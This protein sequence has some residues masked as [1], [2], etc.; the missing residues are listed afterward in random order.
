MR[1]FVYA[2]LLAAAL[3]SGLAAP[4]LAAPAPKKEVPV[5]KKTEP[6]SVPAGLSITKLPNGLMVAIQKDDRFPLAALRLYVHAGSAY[7]TPQQAGISHQLEHMVFKGTEKRPKGQVAADVEKAGGYLNAATSF[8]YTVYLTDMPADKWAL[9]LDIL[10]DMAFHPSLDPQELE[11]EKKV[12]LAELQRGEDEPGGRLFK[13]IQA[14][15][16]AGTPYERP[17]IGY[18]ETIKNFT[19]EGIRAYI[20]QHY[21]PQSMLLVVVGKVDPDKVLAEAARQFGDLPNTK[22]VTPPAVIAPSALPAKGPLVTVERT[23]WNKVHLGI[24]FPAYDQNDARSPALEVLSQLLAGDKT[25]YFYRVYKYEK[26]LVDSISAGDYTFERTGLFYISVSLAPDKLEAFWREFNKDLADLSRLTF[27]QEEMDRAKLNLEDS[28]YRHKETLGGMA[29]KLGYFLFFG[30]PEAENNYLAQLK[31]TDQATLTQLMK[32]LFRPERLSATVLLPEKTEAKTAATALP[33][34]AWLRKTLAES[35]PKVDAKAVAEQSAAKGATETLDLGSGRTLILLPDPTLPYAAVDMV[36][37]GGDSL[38]PPDK[39]GLGALSAAVLTRGTSSMNA[40]ALDAYL[41]DR[42]SGL[43]ASSGRQTFSLSM[44][45]PERFAGDLF[46]L[47]QA[48]LSKPALAKE[49]VDRAKKNQEAVIISQEDRPFDLASRKLFP[50]LF[51]SHP[52]GY[53]GTGTLDRVRAYT[54]EDVRAFWAEQ[55]KQPWVMA[56]CGSFDREAVI[57]A[58][59][60]LPAPSAKAAVLKAPSWGKDKTLDVPLKGRQQAHLFLIF[61]T[62]GP[63][64]SD[65]PGLDLLQTILAGQSGLLFRDLRDEQGLGYVVTAFSLRFPLTGALALYTGTEPA[66]MAQAEEGF[67]KVIEELHKKPL[68][69]EELERGKNQMA[70]QYIRSRQ[71]LGSRSQEAATLAATGRPLDAERQRIEKARK[72]TP[73]DLQELARK[74]LDLNKAYTLKVLP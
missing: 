46:G 53:V 55:V 22:A 19:A 15:A 17:I 18:P 58:A 72:L 70:G 52:Y 43:R 23:P 33:D 9:G 50:F 41:A 20:A 42:A 29:S 7:E 56:V 24:A 69:E 8:D 2:G 1:A 35:W 49:E 30:G 31:L 44:R 21:Q 65:D 12:V 57:K 37:S 34:E 64:S 26:Q 54:R 11:S 10:K 3:T 6:S 5:T 16:L 14:L 48:T 39:Q 67:R 25:S 59:K 32:D 28:L 71:S 45:Y 73:K 4:A 40:P 74:Y 62:V 60:A 27:T 61:P 66:K 47:L 68:P 63:N 13:R 36:F 51:G 38:L